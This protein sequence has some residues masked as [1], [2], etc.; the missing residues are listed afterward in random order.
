MNKIFIIIS[1]LLLAFIGVVMRLVPH[2]A[3]FTPVF[4]IALFAGFYLSKKW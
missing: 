2:P 4:A 3:N 1:L